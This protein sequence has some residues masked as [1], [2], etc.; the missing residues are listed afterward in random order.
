MENAEK[1]FT[2]LVEA[3]DKVK[4]GDIVM[5]EP[6][7][8]P[9]SYVTPPTEATPT[10]GS[11]GG[12]D[13]SALK[14]GVYPKGEEPNPAVHFVNSSSVDAIQH[15]S[16]MTSQ[17]HH[18]TAVT[19][20]LSVT[21]DS[22]YTSDEP[23]PHSIASSTPLIS[24]VVTP[25]STVTPDQ[26]STGAVTPSSLDTDQPSSDGM[27]L[28]TTTPRLHAPMEISSESDAGLSDVTSK[29]TPPPNV[30][31]PR[32]RARG[33]RAI[34]SAS[35]LASTESDAS[36]SGGGA[37]T[38]ARKKT[39]RTR[40]KPSAAASKLSDDT[41]EDDDSGGGAKTTPKGTRR[42]ACKG[43]GTPAR[44]RS[45][46]ASDSDDTREIKR[47]STRVAINVSKLDKNAMML[48]AEE[49]KRVEAARQKIRDEE[50]RLLKSID[51]ELFKVPTPPTPMLD[52]VDTGGKAIPGQP[53]AKPAVKK[54]FRRGR[55][56]PPPPIPKVIVYPLRI[57]DGFLPPPSG[58]ILPSNHA[59]NMK[60]SG[61]VVFPKTPQEGKGANAPHQNPEELE[62]QA[63]VHETSKRAD[64]VICY[65]LVWR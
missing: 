33:R 46:S 64:V 23:P 5:E 39:S 10:N 60:S 45:A 53:L 63:M 54:G 31:S 58:P 14:M 56:P 61:A 16:H 35:S 28:G 21:A 49:E 57:P 42:R 40:R 29:S 25:T 4:N 32:K 30:P 20:A 38:G 7:I 18:L 24:A 51:D 15:D 52:G 65:W 26:S 13:R 9:K 12:G 44:S 1:T 62:T 48:M 22:K 27:E 19:R 17:I 2:P 8:T 3:P 37:V 55:Q 6:G 34:S 50:K 11:G 43:T 47:R 59:F 41:S 36:G